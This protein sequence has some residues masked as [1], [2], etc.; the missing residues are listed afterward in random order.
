M[1]IVV[2]HFYIFLYKRGLILSYSRRFSKLKYASWAFPPG[3]QPGLWSGPVGGDL[4]PLLIFSFLWSLRNSIW[5][6]KRWYDIKCLEKAL[7][8]HLQD[9]PIILSLKQV[10][11]ATRLITHS[12]WS[13]NSKPLL[14]NI[15]Y[16]PFWEHFP[17]AALEI[18]PLLYI[19]RR[20]L[21]HW[22]SAQNLNLS[23]EIFRNKRPWQSLGQKKKKSKFW[24]VWLFLFC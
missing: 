15:I 12:P 3:P 9:I 11:K 13:H 22:F 7:L 6:T 16:W 17:S 19:H 18:H 10:R 8:C 5:S 20:P 24:K 4:R 23:Y 1:I 21:R 14:K 2:S